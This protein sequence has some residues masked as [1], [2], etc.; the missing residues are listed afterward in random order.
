LKEKLQ[1]EKQA[2]KKIRKSFKEEKKKLVEEGDR[3]Q[4]LA[5]RVSSLDDEAQKLTVRLEEEK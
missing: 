4:Q 1:E 2:K 5:E 3:A